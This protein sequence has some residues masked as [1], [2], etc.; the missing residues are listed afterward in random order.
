MNAIES[1]N[2]RIAKNT[3]ILYVRMIVM[4]FISFYTAR[5]TLNALGVNDFGINN[6]VGGLVSMFS[7]LSNSLS[8]TTSRF[9]TFGLGHGDLD[10]LKKIFSTTINIH[11]VL[12]II[13]VISIESVGVWFLN[14]RMTIPT[15]RLTAA[16]WVLQSSVVVFAVGLLSVPYNS[17]IIAHEKMSAFAYMTI[18]DA[19]FKLTIAFGIY[20]YGGDKLILL[21]I[22]TAIQSVIRQAVYWI[23]CKRNFEECVY[24]KG[25]NRQME[26]S[27]FSFAGWNFI[28]STAA[29][30]KDQG[31]NIVINIFT[32]P[33][34]NA[35]R[36]IAMQINNTIN[37]FTN[38]FTMALNPQI[39][40]TYAVGDL[41][42]MHKLIIQGTRLS[43]F[44]FMILSIPI[45]F[46][47][48][49]ILY[50]WLGNIPEHT[51]SF[52][53]LILILTLSE[54]LSNTLIVAQGATG[55][56]KKYQL[57]VGSIQLL[58]FPFSYI[59]LEK[60]LPPESTIVIAIILAQIC[61]FVRLWLLHTM[62]KLPI[63]S[64]LKKVYLNSIV[65]TTIATVL[66]FCCYHFITNSTVRF[67]GVCVTSL[68]SSFL[69][70]YYLG[71]N[72]EEKALVKNSITNF[73]R[74]F[75]N[76]TT[77]R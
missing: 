29:L 15:E 68:F 32:G 30:M 35:A 23:Y 47:M 4:M 28:G 5:I 37:Q 44:L 31:V 60:G 21:S 50:I 42:R 71:L 34:V 16:N 45:Y 26:K 63:V 3:I 17:A 2:K 33:A 20:Y 56:I 46:E 9:M 36:G 75:S 24:T 52:A 19:V 58:N 48:N 66:P 74:K 51:T 11:V 40:K 72:K 70:I 55:N 27:I 76:V 59:C 41:N 22:L 57:I 69:T 65:V 67:Y 6:V 7:L 39:T 25:R 18:F 12:A 1:E 49:S 73:R 43:F 10:N 13:V 62:I 64:F 77:N 14:N 61:F 38:N 54:I 8:S 53:R